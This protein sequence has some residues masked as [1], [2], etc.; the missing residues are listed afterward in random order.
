MFA[1]WGAYLSY[2]LPATIQLC[3]EWWMYEVVI[4][5]AGIAHNAEIGQGVMGLLFQ[6]SACA[7][8]SSLAYGSSVNTRVGNELGAGNA[9]AAKLSVYTAVV[10]V[11]LVQSVL[12]VA[13][14]LADRQVVGLLSNNKEVEELTISTMP[15]L[16]PTFVCDALNCVA[17]GILRGAGRPGIG[18]VLNSAGYWGLG[19]PLAAYF[20]LYL[21]WSVKGFWLA[22]L[23]TSSFM[24]IVQL[25]VIA[26]F[27]WD[28]EVARS[29]R[30][31]AQHD[32][33]AADAKASDLADAV[34]GP[35]VVTAVSSSWDS[36]A[37]H[38]EMVY[39]E[40]GG[41][42][43]SDTAPLLDSAQVRMQGGSA[44]AAAA[45]RGKPSGHRVSQ[46]HQQRTSDQGM[47]QPS[48][49]SRVSQVEDQQQQEQNS[50]LDSQLSR[51]WLQWPFTGGSPAQAVQGTQPQ[52]QLQQQN[53]LT[54]RLLRGSSS[55]GHSV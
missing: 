26:R 52:P 30:L 34:S 18:A 53:S 36:I 16:L 9:E 48:K 42:G 45:A 6:I 1:G 4:F 10:M 51:A 12:A 32:D 44:A 14:K 24:V 21:G 33:Q 50:S 38:P 25:A 15:I 3:T 31:M 55:S 28:K 22:L 17:Q 7:Y 49:L 40:Q 19:V 35:V 47:W 46:Q 2:G 23:T 37:A 27:D 39:D 29:A 13:C 43:V 8:M 11:A 41:E 20:G 54:A 5:M